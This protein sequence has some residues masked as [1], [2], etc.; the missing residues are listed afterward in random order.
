M[1]IHLDYRYKAF[2][3]AVPGTGGVVTLAG[4]F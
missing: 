4:D 1:R 3:N 2:G